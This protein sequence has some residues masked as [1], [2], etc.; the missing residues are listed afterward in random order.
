[1]RIN[2]DIPIV[3]N[4]SCGLSRVSSKNGF[5]QSASPAIALHAQSALCRS[6]AMGTGIPGCQVR[7]SGAAGVGYHSLIKQCWGDTWMYSSWEGSVVG[8]VFATGQSVRPEGRT[9]TDYE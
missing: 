4:T 1:M 5:C 7:F 3:F 6:P 2:K 9:R 8:P